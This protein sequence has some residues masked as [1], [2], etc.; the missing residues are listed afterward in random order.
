MMGLHAAQRNAKGAQMAKKIIHVNLLKVRSNA[1][2]GTL[3]PV[4]AVKQRGRTDYAHE[5]LING[6]SRIVYS[7]NK[8]LSCGARVWIETESDVG[9]VIVRQD[10]AT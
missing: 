2:H 1:R 4:I 3:D 5:V 9:C 6:P 10:N 8:P 7:P